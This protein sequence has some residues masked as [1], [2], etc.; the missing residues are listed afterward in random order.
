MSSSHG[1]PLSAE[2]RRIFSLPAPAALR[3]QCAVFV[4]GPLEPSGLRRAVERLVADHEILR[5]T[6]RRPPGRKTPFQVILDA[7]SV[8]WRVDEVDA[9]TDDRVSAARREA[10]R[11]LREESEAPLDLES[12]PILS[13]AAARF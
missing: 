10:E 11:L 13:V 6:Y 7:P 5:T 1:F 2:Q 3:V 8:R 4:E 12:G 9:R